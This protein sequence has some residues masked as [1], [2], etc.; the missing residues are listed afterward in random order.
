MK[1]H[2]PGFSIGQDARTRTRAALDFGFSQQSDGASFSNTYHIAYCL[3]GYPS[4]F[5]D[6][7]TIFNLALPARYPTA[8][9][10]SVLPAEGRRGLFTLPGRRRPSNPPHAFLFMRPL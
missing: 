3:S 10:E 1:Q 7:Y 6:L 4:L 9:C 8:V 2:P 5:A